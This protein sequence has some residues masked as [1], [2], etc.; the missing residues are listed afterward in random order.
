M[1]RHVNISEGE[2][3]FLFGV[4]LGF[5]GR[6]LL[7]VGND[8]CYQLLWRYAIVINISF[9]DGVEGSLDEL[10]VDVDAF[11]GFHVVVL[12]VVFEFQLVQHFVIVLVVTSEG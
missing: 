9:F 4:V 11:E 3:K 7:F 12:E 8:S 5:S 6:G 1:C 2:S 10:G